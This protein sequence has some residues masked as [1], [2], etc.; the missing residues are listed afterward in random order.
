M[1]KPWRFI[2]L[3][4]TVVFG[5]FDQVI[6]IGRRVAKSRPSKRYKL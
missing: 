6:N 2:H 1:P 4:M 3:L 5:S